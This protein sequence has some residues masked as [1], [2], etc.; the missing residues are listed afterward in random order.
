MILPI[1]H[2]FACRGTTFTKDGEQLHL[3]KSNRW[4][5][6]LQILVMSLCQIFQKTPYFNQKIRTEK[7]GLLVFLL[8]YNQKCCWFCLKFDHG[9]FFYVFFKILFIFHGFIFFIVIL[10]VIFLALCQN[11][12]NGFFSMMH[13]LESSSASV[14]C[15]VDSSLIVVPAVQRWSP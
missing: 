3:S 2:I 10:Q 5:L 4:T 15:L 7:I 9:F 6:F 11:H 8:F 14:E 1:S 12:F 13:Q